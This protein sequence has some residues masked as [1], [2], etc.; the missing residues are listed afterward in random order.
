MIERYKEAL[1]KNETIIESQP[2][3]KSDY[4]DVYTEKV[5][6]VA[7]RNVDAKRLQT[8]DRIITY[9]YRNNVFKVVKPKW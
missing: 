6:K 5:N 3:F 4:H 1:F 7:L 9:P 2:Q 8:F